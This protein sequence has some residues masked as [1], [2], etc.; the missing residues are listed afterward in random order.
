MAISFISGNG[1]KIENNEQNGYVPNNDN[2]NK[3]CFSVECLMYLFFF[4][5]WKIPRH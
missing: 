2:N 5:S 4:F 1:L 3:V